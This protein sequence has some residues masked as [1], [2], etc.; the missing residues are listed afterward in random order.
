M[1]V[2]KKG[3]K[4]SH[5][6]FRVR[7]RKIRDALLWLKENNKY[8]HNIEISETNLEVLP[9]DGYASDLPCVESMEANQEDGGKQREHPETKS[10][11]HP[12]RGPF[13]D[14]ASGS[15]E[16]EDTLSYLPSDIS[17]PLEL[18][19]IKTCLQNATNGTSSTDHVLDWPAIG[20]PMNEYTTEGLASKC[21]PC[22][23]PYSTGDPF[24]YDLQRPVKLAETAK[25]LINYCER[26]PQSG[27]LH[28]RFAS[29]KLFPG[30]INDIKRRHSITQ[31]GSIFVKQNPGE[32]PATAEQLLE[33]L[34]DRDQAGA[35]MQKLSRYVANVPGSNAYW[36]AQ[37]SKL[38]ALSDSL[39]PAHVFYSM[40]M[41]DH[42]C[43]P[44]LVLK[45]TPLS[46]KRGIFYAHIHTL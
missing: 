39:G 41:A 11:E 37:R 43:M 33:K 34:S 1:V 6:D 29:H 36:I 26:D 5:Q 22:L 19:A 3:S 10:F 32:I 21:F 35:W 4:E 28:W 14:G 45:K 24:Q 17:K 46:M 31:Q 44:S 40:S 42:A 30:W 15:D 12:D 8:Y 16:I 9:L 2:R 7:Q 25:H 27:R 23:F 18:D 13:Q 38:K 20:M